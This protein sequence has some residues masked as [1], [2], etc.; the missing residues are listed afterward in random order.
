[1]EVNLKAV[2]FPTEEQC[3][4]VTD[5]LLSRNK[6]FLHQIADGTVPPEQFLLNAITTWMMG[7]V[8]VDAT[9]KIAQLEEGILKIKKLH[10]C[11]CTRSWPRAGNHEDSCIISMADKLIGAME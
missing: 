5:M 7:H 11:T 10:G 8:D 1:M 3:K 9:R 6:Q 2:P 4:W